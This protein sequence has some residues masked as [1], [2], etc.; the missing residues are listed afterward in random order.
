MPYFVSIGAVEQ[1]KS[2]VG[3]KGY[4]LFR[5]GRR[6]TTRW[7]PVAVAPGRKFY[8]CSSTREKRFLHRTEKSA[9]LDMKER[10]RQRVELEGYSRLPTGVKIRSAKVHL[11]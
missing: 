11:N 10:I 8:W 5:R 6:I 7:G 1:N 3:S 9:R 4:H 2:G